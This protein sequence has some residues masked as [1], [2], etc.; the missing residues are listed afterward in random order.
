MAGREGKRGLNAPKGL[1]PAGRELW[2]AAQRHLRAQETWADTDGPLLESYVRAVC[3][4]RSA[5]RAA[6]TNPFVEGS[7]GQLVAHPGLKVA[8][9]AER[10][11]CRYATELL[12]TP[13]ARKRHEIKAP[14]EAGVLPFLASVG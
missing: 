5:R 2:A 12:L 13:G 11:A 10:D 7:K 1:D 6:D 8:A 4:A 3:L 9:E 14:E